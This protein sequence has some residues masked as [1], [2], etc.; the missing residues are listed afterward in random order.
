VT[1]TDYTPI[2]CDRYSEYEVY[3]L[4]R[5]WLRVD[6]DMPDKVLT[7]LRCRAT[8]LQTRDRAEFICLQPEAGE[9]LWVRLDHLRKVL[10]WE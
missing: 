10:P 5:T 1:T 6:A 4:R 9:V 2:A 7:D 3:I 8:D